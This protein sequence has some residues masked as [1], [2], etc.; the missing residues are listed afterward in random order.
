MKFLRL[1]LRCLG[2]AAALAAVLLLLAIAPPVQTWLARTELSRHP[3]L[4][5]SLGTLSAGFGR[6]DV[7]ELRLESGGAVL[8]FP[9][10]QAGVPLTRSLLRGRA[11]V[12][13]L[14]A[15][16]WILDLSGEAAP[17]AAEAPAKNAARAFAGLLAAWKPPFDFSLDGA[18]LE[19]D[20]ILPSQAGAPSVR[21][22]VTLT[23]GGVTSEQGGA[24]AFEAESD[25]PG[26]SANTA[27]EAARQRLGRRIRAPRAR[28]A[29]LEVAARPRWR[30]AARLPEDLTGD[31][32]AGASPG[33]PTGR[34]TRWTWAAGASALAQIRG[35]VR[36]RRRGVSEGT[37]RVD[38]RDTRR[39][40][41]ALGR[42]LPRFQQKGAGSYDSDPGLTRFSFHRRI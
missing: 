39:G 11:I 30:R 9:S 15:K 33:A 19:G 42:T 34:A 17:A 1:L 25:N 21:V 23:G 18:A 27:A 16:G 2:F 28:C 32:E 26:F 29:A 10:L 41:F 13:S 22:H 38:L 8:T 36:R 6:V 4:K 37:W 3:G 40:P 7:A 12:R 20:V 35:E 24:L 14:V 5:G 31:G